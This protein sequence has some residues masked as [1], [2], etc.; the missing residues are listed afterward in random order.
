M[1]SRSLAITAGVA[2]ACL[3]LTG[4]GRS[5]D[6]AGG[7][8]TAARELVATTPAATTDF[9][10]VV[11]AVYRDIQTL[12]PAYTFD[13]P[14]NTG[15][16]L[17]CE[18]IMK[19]EPD[20]KIVPGIAD[21]EWVDDTTLVLN[22]N[23]DAKFWDGSAVSGEDVAF[24]ITRHM[25]PAVGSFFAQVYD[26][27][28]D[29]AVTGDKQVTLTLSQPDYWLVG[30]LTGSSGIVLQKKFV[31]EKGA[32]YGTPAGGI[33]CTGAYTLDS[34]VPSTGVVAVPNADYWKGDAGPMLS[35]I[36][37]K[38]VPDEAALTSALL[39]GEVHGT[40][41]LALPTLA[42]LQNSE[43]VD[44]YEG[45][46][47]MTDALVISNFDGALG[48][49]RVRQALSLAIDRE[50]F[51]A[52]VYKDAAQMPRWMSNEGTLGGSPDV[53]GPAYEAAP[54][55]TQDIEKAKELIKE[56][57][58]EGQTITIGSS[59]G[60]SG[61]SASAAAYQAAGEAI[62]IKVEIE[63]VSPDTYIN[64]FID[65]AARETV[66]AFTTLNYGGY[67]DPA[68][69]LGTIVLPGG[70][71]NYSGFDDPEI[72]ALMEEARSTADADARAEL[73][74][75]VSNLTIEQ[76]PWIPN[77]QPTNVLVMNKGLTGADSSFSYMFTSWANNL[78][79]K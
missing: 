13:Y 12:D 10:S 66:D 69:M 25:D 42:E 3:A 21:V 19:A 4:C 55:L 64:Y 78:G 1:S 48:D 29:V 7:G 2:I 33:M 18:T 62:G 72:T 23:P 35:E 37:L 24:S 17:M 14:D 9:G 59:A 65:P 47:Q 71:Q 51:I 76:L 60:M 68:S 8:E 58:A 63:S 6:D 36:T 45:P 30:E 20:G 54:E 57:G 46:S 73:M 50:A 53:Y 49:V 22:V 43:E 11:W 61:V 34:W 26:R 38:G 32:D 52:N 74:V 40:Y 70:S 15:T 27:V 56:A 39:T 77:A 16:T 75:K 79:G 5:I 67:P 31:E 28:S 44:V 41:P